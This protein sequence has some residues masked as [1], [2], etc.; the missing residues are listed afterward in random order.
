MVAGAFM[1]IPR[2]SRDAEA[3]STAPITLTV[4]V[5]QTVDSL[6][7]FSGTL[8]M[9][10]EVYVL[11]YEMLVGVDKDL[12]PVPQIAESW[13]HNVDGTVWTY[14]IRHGMTWHDGVPVTAN[15]VNFTYN[16]ILTSPTAGALNIDYL[17]NVTDVRALD[18]YTLQIT[19]EVPKATMQ[20]IIISIVPEHLWGAIPPEEVADAD[21]FD[22]TYFPDGPVGSGPFKLV[23]AATDDFWKFQRYNDYW[24]P[25]VHFDELTFK[26]FTSSSAILNALYSGSIDIAGGVPSDSWEK[27][28]SKPGIR[29]QAVHEL[30]LTELGINTCPPS[31]RPDGASTNYETLNLSVRKAIAMAVNKTQMVRDVIFGL[32][33]PGD[34]FIPPASV[35]WHY[36]L[37]SSEK[38]KFDIAAANALLDAAGYNDSNRDGIRENS[39]SGVALNFQFNFIVDSPENEADAYLIQGW[40]EQIG[41]K[42]APQ[43]IS[44]ST[45]TD[46]WYGMKYDMFIWGWGGDA[47]PSFIASVFTT[48][49]IPTAETGYAAWS[50][51]FYSNPYYDSLFVQQQNTVDIAAR[52]AILYEMQRII[53]RDSP[54]VILYNA[55][56]LYAYR[57]DR[58]TNWPDIT[59]HPGMTPLSGFTGGPWLYYE[60]LPYSGNLPPRNVDA[61]PDTTLALGE[62]RSFTGY[63]ED[64]DQANLTWTWNISEPGD[65]FHELTGRTI[66]YTFDI[67]G[68]VLITLTVGDSGDPSLD[69][70]DQIV[71]TVVE[72]AQAG[73][74]A[75]YVNDNEGHAIAAADVTA[76]L[77]S[78]TTDLTG[79]YNMTLAPGSYDVTASREGY[80]TGLEA[81]TVVLNQTTTLDFAL[82]NNSGSLRGH[83]YYK[84]TT[85]PLE[86]V[87]V[88][89]R[90]G[91]INKLYLTDASGAYNID[92]LEA[93]TYSVN[94][95]KAG[96]ETNMTSVVI[97]VGL[98][99]ILDARLE[100]LKTGGGVSTVMLAAI[101]AIIVIVAV[102]VV[103][104]MLMR[105]KKEPAEGQ[106]PKMPEPPKP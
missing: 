89:V 70:R 19:T 42:A 26:Y 28:L 34:V 96:Y 53:Y 106:P 105:R 79:Y 7:P 94:V 104:L 75:G 35:R 88:S 12:N 65:V 39:T 72:L 47:D 56:G 20:S 93:G 91:D 77:S 33:E 5:G 63:A 44:E 74:L 98:E 51:C 48:G 66:S 62:T 92:M 6:N 2:A 31:L 81:T 69:D 38:Y 49:Q 78:A 43:G 86:G 27:T 11:M 36:N 102:A 29:G 100:P 59:A 90:K 97:Q 14:H 17:K 82:T 13:E 40:L 16:L 30:A 24:G 60:I 67:E 15:D 45:L 68:T 52:Q 3:A 32:A 37:T 46:Y 73:W 21:V 41:I 23:S 1:T 84:D 25:K 10:Y 58:F 76:E 22:T 18:D 8:T 9:A 101:A 54:Y 80:L 55:F 83:V 85:N 57:E 95:T 61:G 99:K 64:E 71:A 87:V 103:V 50:D 4:G